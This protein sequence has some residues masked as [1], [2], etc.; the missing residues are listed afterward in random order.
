MKIRLPLFFLLACIGLL[1]LFGNKNGRASQSGKGNTGAPGDE[2]FN[3]A[4]YTCAGCHNDGVFNPVIFISVL[5]TGDLA[6]THYTPG[7][8]YNAR[9]TINASGTNLFGYGF[10]MIALRDTG[11]IDLDGFTD[12]NPNNYKIATISNGRTYAEHANISTS[13]TFNVRWTAPSAGTGS[14]TF[15]AA[16]NAVNGNGNDNGDGATSTSLQLMENITLSDGGNVPQTATTI[17][18]LP[19]PVTDMAQ[20]QMNLPDAG[21]YQLTVYHQ[22]GKLQ[23]MSE[24]NLPAGESN[25]TLNSQ[26]W[27][28]GIYLVSIISPKYS[29]TVKILKL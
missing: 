20:V 15:Y 21:K 13:N 7:K 28:P 29:K 23:W 27:P 17:R 19:N 25:H 14:V 18:V 22:T 16:G 2:F 12:I 8:L 26:D 1:T 11:N 4:P 9:V 24:Q 6:I 5:D 3:G 10:Q